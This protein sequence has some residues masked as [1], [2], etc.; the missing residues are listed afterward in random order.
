MSDKTCKKKILVVDDDEISLEITRIM[1][2]N[3]YEAITAKSGKIA[4]ERLEHFRYGVIPDLILLGAMMP[5]TEGGE[6]FR[7]IKEITSSKKIPVILSTTL[8]EIE[9][10]KLAANIESDGYIVKPYSKDDLLNKIKS[11]IESKTKNKLSKNE[12][13]RR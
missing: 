9:K 10:H 1:L 7:K 5:L 3:D 11:V 4:L 2:K 12:T 13:V 8:K 6:T